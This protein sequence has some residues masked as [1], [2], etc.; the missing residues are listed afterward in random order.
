[1]SVGAP[2]I[3][4]PRVATRL[5]CDRV[6][7]NVGTGDVAAR[8]ATKRCDEVELG[9]LDLTR[10]ALRTVSRS[11]RP[12]GIL[13]P[14]GVALR[15]GDVIFEDD[16]SCIVVVHRPSEVW[17]IRAASSNALAT[18]ALELGNMH[19]PVEVTVEGDLYTPPDGPTEGV[20][21]RA[22]VSYELCERR[23]VPLRA[24]VTSG[25]SVAKNLVVRSVS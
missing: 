10:R 11:G 14:L 22:G 18:I 9:W 24:T 17:R 3:S 23:F 20:L 7:A 4:A 15:H 8:L 21:R 5:V 12:I 6:L 1:M 13:L 19:V 25:L 16:A 2:T